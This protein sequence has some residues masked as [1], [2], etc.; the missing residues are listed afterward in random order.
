MYSSKS[1][2][3]NGIESV[4]KYASLEAS[5]ERKI[6]MSWQPYFVLKAANEEPIGTSAMYCSTDDRD[7]G[8]ESVKLNAPTAQLVDM[9]M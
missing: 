5:Y 8:I 3:E 2:A 1:G 6:S 9:T 4:K 7:E